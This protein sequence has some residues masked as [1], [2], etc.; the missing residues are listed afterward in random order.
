MVRLQRYSSGWVTVATKRTTTRATFTFAVTAPAKV[1]K[2]HRYRVVAPRTRTRAAVTTAAVQVTAVTPVRLISPPRTRV[3]SYGW[4]ASRAQLATSSRY[5][6]YTDHTDGRGRVYDRTTRTTTSQPG[7]T[8]EDS[9][10]V[11][12]FFNP[13]SRLVTRRASG[14]YLTERQD[15]PAYHTFNTTLDVSPDGNLVLLSVSLAEHVFGGYERVQNGL[16]LLDR[17]A[18]TWTPLPTPAPAS[19]NEYHYFNHG[20]LSSDGMKVVY[21]DTRYVP[22]GDTGDGTYFA[23]VYLLDRQAGTTT[24]V[25]RT[26]DGLPSDRGSSIGNVM[27]GPPTISDDGKVIYFHTGSRN[28]TT[29]GKYGLLRFDV[30]TGTLRHLVEF[31]FDTP[32]PTSH[33]GRYVVYRWGAWVWR[34]DAVTGQRRLVNVTLDEPGRTQCPSRTWTC[35]ATASSSASSPEP[36]TWPP[37]PRGWTAATTGPT[38]ST[39]GHELGSNG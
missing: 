21:A 22:D 15:N 16:F 14:A 5:V 10:D 30:A 19:G 2:G 23:E 34:L 28:L 29:N 36:P 35:P 17:V 25:S 13:A 7:S 1:G 4:Q 20:A 39:P 8:G 3:S 32:A 27:N 12:E 6:Y 11:V 38:C 26:L 31:T 18:D 33:D 37:P 9:L 24:L